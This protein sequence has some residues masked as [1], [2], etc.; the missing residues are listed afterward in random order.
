M[1][2]PETGS[3]RIWWILAI[4]AVSAWCLYLYLFGPTARLEA[5]VLEGTALAMP[6]DY[7]WT[8]HDLDGRPVPLASYR[9]KAVL[10]NIWAT[11][12]PPCIEELPSI[13]ELARSPRLADVAF[14]CVS[15]DEDVESV[16]RFRQGKDWPMTFLHAGANGLPP[17]FVT[18]GGGIPATFLIAPDG[19]IAASIVGSADWDVPSVVDFLER[20]A[21]PEPATA[22]KAE[23]P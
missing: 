21:K 11:W 1:T 9:G 19:R 22:P 10:L 5:P 13:A 3:G 15:V 7:S 8:V 2:E 18:G 4:V 16:R 14:L 20:L 17:A 6:A 23:K 12:C